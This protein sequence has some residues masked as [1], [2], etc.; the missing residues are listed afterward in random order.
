MK[1]MK[2]T[3]VILC[4]VI[5]LCSLVMVM[6]VAAA[7]NG[8]IAFTTDRDGN[9][10]IYV[11]NADGTG[12]IRLTNNS[13]QDEFSSWSTDGSKLAFFSDRDANYEI[14]SMNPDG[15]GR[16]VLLTMRHLIRYLPGL[17]MV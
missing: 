5:V 12:Q 13:A 16:P 10:E 8:K 15:S 17:R 11:M 4:I 1:K 2:K 7:G 3:V 6:P 14:Y 9:S